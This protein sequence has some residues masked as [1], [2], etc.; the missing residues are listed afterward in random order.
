MKT[1]LHSLAILFTAFLLFSCKATIPEFEYGSN[2]GTSAQEAPQS[3]YPPRIDRFEADPQMAT[4]GEPITL[5]W[6]TQHATDVHISGVGRVSPSGS[7]TIAS[8][9]IEL[10]DIMLTASNDGNF[11]PATDKL[12][13]QY[14]L[15]STKVPDGYAGPSDK[16][17]II[18]GNRGNITNTINRYKLQPVNKYTINKYPNLKPLTPVKPVQATT[19]AV[20]V[21]PMIATPMYFNM[22]QLTAPQIISPRNNSTFNHYPR[23]LTL[24]WKPVNNASAYNVD[25]DCLNCCVAGK[26]CADVGKKF[27]QVKSQRNTYYQFSFVGAQPGRWRVQAVDKNGKAGKHSPWT[28]FKFTR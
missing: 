25:I 28:N 5:S 16:P 6:E 2:P 18:I 14:T 23:K 4:Q 21:K 7:R 15:F 12:D 3:Q 26:W 13:V 9:G 19:Q 11:A 27:K 20:N 8:P 22:A 17:M 10:Q 1:I 24:R